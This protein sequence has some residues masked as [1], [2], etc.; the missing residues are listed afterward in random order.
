ME[1]ARGESQAK[2]RGRGSGAGVGTSRVEGWIRIFVG[3]E[4]GCGNEHQRE[5]IS[6]DQE[7]EKTNGRGANKS[8]G[9]RRRRVGRA[10]AGL[11]PLFLAT[12]KKDGN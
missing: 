7:K 8:Q 11:E 4:R 6:T 2:R 10:I 12:M 9:H 1:G 5:R 3:R